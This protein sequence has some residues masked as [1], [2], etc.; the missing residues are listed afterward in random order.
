MKD[1]IWISRDQYWSHE[2]GP[3]APTYVCPELLHQFTYQ[4]PRRPEKRPEVKLCEAFSG[5]AKS[6]SHPM[7]DILAVLQCIPVVFHHRLHQ[8]LHEIEQ[9]SVLN[10]SMNPDKTS[11]YQGT[12][13]SAWFREAGR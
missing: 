13:G 6:Y 9:G 2:K 8:L 11:G 3:T 4:V 12:N 5:V 1:I 7:H 10:L